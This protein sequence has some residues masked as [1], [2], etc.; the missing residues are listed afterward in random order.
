MQGTDYPILCI[1]DHLHY[2]TNTAAE[3]SEQ[4]FHEAKYKLKIKTFKEDHK[5][6]YVKTS[7]LFQNS[8]TGS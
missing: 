1:S 8:Y 7:G 5:L 4:Y 6:R 3:Y 2:T